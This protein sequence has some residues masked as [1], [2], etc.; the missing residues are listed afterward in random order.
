VIAEAAV[1]LVVALGN[2]MSNPT[3]P[4][5][6][7]THDTRALFHLDAEVVC[8]T[9]IEPARYKTT[10][11]RVARQAGY[12][13]AGLAAPNPVAVRQS[14]PWRTAT[15]RVRNLS[16]GVARISPDRSATVVVLADGFRR[17]VVVC[18]HLV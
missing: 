9:E 1:V 17:V 6:E 16:R 2:V 7:V 12:R 13:P 3:M 8:A 5:R 4:P 10:F 11:R 15:V 18:A 14:S